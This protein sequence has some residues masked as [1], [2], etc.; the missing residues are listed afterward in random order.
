VETLNK[1]VRVV[2]VAALFFVVAFV[3]LL[4]VN[5]PAKPA[6]VPAAGTANAG[7]SIFATRCASCHGQDGGGSFGPPLRG[8][9]VVQRYPDPA[10]QIAVVTNGRGSMPS[11]AD[12]LTPEQIAA[13]VEFTRTGLG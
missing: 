13:V 11:F 5:E 4:F 8:G 10:D 1:V 9:I 3:V 12:S 7:A 6:P 2:Q